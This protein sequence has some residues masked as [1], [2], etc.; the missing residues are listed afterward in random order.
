MVI[1]KYN[2]SNKGLIHYGLVI[3]FSLVLIVSQL[4]VL[5]FFPILNSVDKM[6]DL[7]GDLIDIEDQFTYEKFETHNIMQS[8]TRAPTKIDG[9]SQWDAKVLASYN[10]KTS[11]C[12]IGDLDPTREGNEIV[13][14]NGDGLVAMVYK[15]KSG[16]FS[17]PP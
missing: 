1:S 4:I 3:A 13:T 9:I 7:D 2:S 14:V 8:H 17:M 10:T 16:S 6:A 5:G 11:G 12:T 15:T